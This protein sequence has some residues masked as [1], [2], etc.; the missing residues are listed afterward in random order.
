MLTSNRD[1]KPSNF[2]LTPKGHLLI[3]D[4][5]SSARLLLPDKEGVQKVPISSCLVLCGT[6]DYISPEI[7]QMQEE[8]LI[9][10]EGENES[11]I[12]KEEGGYGKETDWWSLGAMVYELVYGVAPFFAK[13]V[14]KTYDRII[15]HEVGLIAFT[16]LYY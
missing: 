4:F 6:C 10:L 13:D 14:R 2:V 7:L 5:A 8:A 3:I 15:N 16:E 11:F 1:V 12:P 9:A